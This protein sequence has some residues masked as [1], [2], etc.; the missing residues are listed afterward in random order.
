MKVETTCWTHLL[1]ATFNFL[2]LA[3]TNNPQS[4]T[5]NWLE[6]LE[7]NK[8]S[9]TTICRKVHP[10]LCYKSRRKKG[11]PTDAIRCRARLGS[12]SHINLQYTNSYTMM[13]NKIKSDTVVSDCL[14]SKI[15]TRQIFISMWRG[16]PQ[17]R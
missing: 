8:I 16:G 13:M 7:Y 4:A 11:T 14:Y 1:T 9:P 17:H 5:D 2:T 12:S 6:W 3:V 15:S 10:M